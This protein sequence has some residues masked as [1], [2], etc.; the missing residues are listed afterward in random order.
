MRLLLIQV[1]DSQDGVKAAARLSLERASRNG[2]VV[3][4]S[5]NVVAGTVE[6]ERRFLLQDDER[7]VVE[8]VPT[9]ELV[10]DREHFVVGVRSKAV[11]EDD[12]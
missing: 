2:W 3:E 10:Y 1:A 4:R 11:E 5:W 7:L 9:T 12:E 6:A 8:A